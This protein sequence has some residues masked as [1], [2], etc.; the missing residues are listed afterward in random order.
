M[1]SDTRLRLSRDRAAIPAVLGEGRGR[2]AP[3]VNGPQ[4]NYSRR[5][6]PLP[7]S[8]VGAPRDPEVSQ[9]RG[10]APWTR[11]PFWASVSKK[12]WPHQMQ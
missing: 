4:P 2:K 12:K 1:D 7:S 3:G 9:R 10:K 6:L 8:V 5:A 11:P